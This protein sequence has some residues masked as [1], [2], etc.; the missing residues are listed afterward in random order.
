[1]LWQERREVGVVTGGLTDQ[2]VIL[3]TTSRTSSLGF[4]ES[5][6]RVNVAITRAKR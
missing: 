5:S 4:I 6:R 2:E 1:M 3:L